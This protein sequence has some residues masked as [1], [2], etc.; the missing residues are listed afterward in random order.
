MSTTI[1]PRRVAAV[2]IC[3]GLLVAAAPLYGESADPYVRTVEGVRIH[4]GVVPA[5]VMRAYH[6]HSAEALM[7]HASA[8]EDLP[9][10]KHVM[11][12]LFD[13][14]TGQRITAARVS[15]RI[16]GIRTARA[17]RELEPMRVAG[18]MTFGNF[19]PMA[20]PGSYEIRVEVQLPDRARPLRTSFI[21]PLADD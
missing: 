1:S 5:E 10:E 19:L 21:Y 12:A 6:R 7:H 14:A 20:G 4:L 8:H 15:A 16:A 11:V 2:A 9:G 13:A 17:T 18:A 3:I